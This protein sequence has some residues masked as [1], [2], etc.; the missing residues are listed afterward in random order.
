MVA[1]VSIKSIAQWLVDGVECY[2]TT[3]YERWTIEWS[4]GQTSGTLRPATRTAASAI[5]MQTGV[6]GL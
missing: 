4:V 5:Q 2:E 3:P 6:D 1:V